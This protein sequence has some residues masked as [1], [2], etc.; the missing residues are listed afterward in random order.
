MAFDYS[1]LSYSQL[2]SL[3]QQQHPEMAQRGYTAQNADTQGTGEDP[4][5]ALLDLSSLGLPGKAAVTFTPDQGAVFNAESPDGGHRVALREGP[6]GGVN[7]QLYNQGD[8]LFDKLIPV[9]VALGTGA[10]AL[11]AISGAGVA[12]A[13]EG[14]SGAI[15]SGATSI[16]G[17]L[18]S[19]LVSAGSGL[20]PVTAADIASAGGGG[21]TESAASSAGGLFS[22]GGGLFG[23]GNIASEAGSTA[24]TNPVAAP[25]GSDVSSITAP[26]G[27]DTTTV[28][29]GAFN[30][31]GSQL[32]GG[33][34]ATSTGS[35]LSGADQ[36]SNETTKLLGQNSAQPGSLLNTGAAS[37]DTTGGGFLD[38]LKNLGGSNIGSVAGNVLGSVLQGKTAGNVANTLSGAATQGAGLQSQAA[39][40]AASIL[41]G[42]ATGA[43]KTISDAYLAQGKSLGDA[44]RAAGVSMSDAQLKSAGIMADAY[45]TAAQQQMAG[46]RNAMVEADKTLQQQQE[47][48][49][50]YQQAG[51]EALSQLQ[52]GLKPGGQY[53][54]AFTMADAQ[55]MPAYQFAL[56][57]GKEAINNAAGA[58]GLQLSSANIQSLGKFAEGTAAQYEQQA[59]NQWMSQ[60]NLSLGAL[61]NLVQTGQISTGQLQQA[62]AQH[63]VSM[64][65]LQ[66]NLGNAQAQGT[67][68]AAGAQAQG[69]LGSTNA[70]NTGNIG[71]AQA[72]GQAGLGSAGALAAGQVGAANAQAAGQVGA[73]NAQATG[74]NQAAN[75]QAAGT[76]QQGNI[77]SQG[78]NTLASGLVKYGGDIGSIFGFGG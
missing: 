65:T 8:T 4:N 48:Q 3:L 13:V 28:G 45:G 57:Q 39:L 47:I 15:G 58:G 52:E 2:M 78:L 64:E 42:A 67:L 70:L 61:Q 5:T 14:G 23:Q 32:P 24:I 34:P 31:L 41:S 36:L 72:E 22:D 55:N 7:A 18:T 44:L 25:I 73:A 74:I 53:N 1:K 60:N 33:L 37:T 21:L 26:T 16:P 50:P 12:G 71:A 10:A 62:L 51:T 20:N 46:I 19:E 76:A 56:E 40:N 43:G 77:W 29:Q 35:G 9:G 66:Q 63:G 69:V 38:Q 68:G 30:N 75:A 17:D 6:G 49:K 59:F 27:I 54:R 11:S